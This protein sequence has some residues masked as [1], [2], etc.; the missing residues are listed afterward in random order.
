MAHIHVITYAEYETNKSLM[1]PN[2]KILHES[3]RYENKDQLNDVQQMIAS[4]KCI[5][6]SEADLN[7]Y[8]TIAKERS[9]TGMA[10]DL[11]SK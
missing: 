7:H 6:P 10:Y 9:V 2:D 11:G 8:E 5:I 1:T 4:L 3:F